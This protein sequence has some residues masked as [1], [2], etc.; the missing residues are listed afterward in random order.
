VAHHQRR[1]S[2]AARDALRS[3]YQPTTEGRRTFG[4]KLSRSL[5]AAS[6]K[7][8]SCGGECVAE[9]VPRRMAL[10][11][12]CF[13]DSRLPKTESRPHARASAGPAVRRCGS[14]QCPG[15]QPA[16]ARAVAAGVLQC[17]PS[18]PL[19]GYH[20]VSWAPQAPPKAGISGRWLGPGASSG[21][22][23]SKAGVGRGFRPLADS[24]VKGQWDMGSPSRLRGKG[25]SGL[26][27]ERIG[28]AQE[29]E[30]RRR[31]SPR[32]GARGSS[33][34]PASPLTR[35]GAPTGRQINRGPSA[36]GDQSK[37]SI[38]GAT[39]NRQLLFDGVCRCYSTL[40][41]PSV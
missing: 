36:P 10:H 7:S 4:F 20:A 9:V 16:R 22:S 15:P 37:R 33:D 11:A 25:P 29:A 6:T 31:L 21:L 38:A 12:G 26:N 40:S 24:G 5:L 41:S 39:R 19:A 28:A 8:D 1:H 30:D 27:M 34:S 13:S 14:W 17:P 18:G 2:H 35:F 32:W 23:M 3:K